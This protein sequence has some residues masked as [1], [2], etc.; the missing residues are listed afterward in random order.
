MSIYICMLWIYSYIHSIFHSWVYSLLTKRDPASVASATDPARTG[1]LVPQVLQVALF[2]TQRSC[3]E[4]FHRIWV[5]ML[6][7]V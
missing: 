2:G 7:N 6:N 3:G 5:N 4:R 1:A